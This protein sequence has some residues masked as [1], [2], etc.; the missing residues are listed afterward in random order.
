MGVE[1]CTSACDSLSPLQCFCGSSPVT[2]KCLCLSDRSARSSCLA[3]L[4]WSNVPRWSEFSTFI[5]SWL[6][7][8]PVPGL[9]ARA[10]G[11]QEMGDFFIFMNNFSEVGFILDYMHQ[12]KFA[13]DF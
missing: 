11:T 9:G 7:H 12:L 1:E 8:F 4:F 6:V 3:P 5:D 2:T 13:A 10:A